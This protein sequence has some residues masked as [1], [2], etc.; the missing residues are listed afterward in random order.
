MSCDRWREA[1][2]AVVDDEEPSVDVRLLDAHLQRCAECRDYRRAAEHARRAGR[3][4]P[5]SRPD[6]DLPRRMARLAA[7]ADR[8]A[9]WS[10]LRVMLSV[11]AIEIIVFSVPDL[12][13]TDGS[14][15]THA[16]RHLGA[17]TVAYGAGLLVVVVRPARARAMLPVTAV[18]AGAL[19]ITAVVDL[20]SKRIPLLGEAGHLP[21][22]LSVVLVW[23]MTVPTPGRLGRNRHRNG[24]EDVRLHVVDDDDSRRTG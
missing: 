5:V 23:L 21:E 3:I 10:V 7:V 19:L 6:D 11:V 24:F 4:H 16:A 12:L 18:L 8:A 2:S 14:T 9:R 20:A 15:S 1:I 22:L 17:F 13:G